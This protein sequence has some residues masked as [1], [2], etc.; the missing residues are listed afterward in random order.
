MA[1]NQTNATQEGGL[2]LST[3]HS[4]RFYRAL[5]DAI[6]AVNALH[7]AAK[8]FPTCSVEAAETSPAVAVEAFGGILYR[9]LY[10]ML[11]LHDGNEPDDGFEGGGHGS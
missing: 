7:V 10:A 2:R 4:R 1:D 11:S 8:T 5:C 3:E 9:R 6:D